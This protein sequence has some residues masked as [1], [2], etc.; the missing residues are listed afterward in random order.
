MTE[1]TVQQISLPPAAERFVLQW[2][3][4]GGRWGVNRSVGQIHA[5]LYLSEKPLTADDIADQLGMARSNVSNSLKELQTWRLIKR[6]SVLGDRRDYF[7]AETDVWEMFLRI[8]AGRKEREIDPAIATLRQCVDATKGDT[9]LNPVSAARLSDMLD[10]VESLNR[11]YEQMQL[12]P[13]S[14][15]M[16]LVKMGSRIANF[17]GGRRRAARERK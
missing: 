15:L 10:V 14:K 5:L 12:L 17:L 1:I 2:G 8:V 13:K 3:D 6:V 9:R 16:T 11:W 7:E 4:L